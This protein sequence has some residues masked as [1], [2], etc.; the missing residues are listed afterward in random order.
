[1]IR[2]EQQQQQE[3]DCRSQRARTQRWGSF[4]RGARISHL[5][6]RI[7]HV[8]E[9]S[10]TVRDLQ[11][12]KLT[13]EEDDEPPCG[14]SALQWSSRLSFGPPSTGRKSCLTLIRP[15]VSRVAR[16]LHCANTSSRPFDHQRRC[17]RD[18]I[19]MQHLQ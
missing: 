19:Q 9:E 14:C 11:F 18:R 8:G 2:G 13:S 17:I 16:G 10:V 12:E 15:F 4:R 1:M 5:P 6:P 7:Q 3:E